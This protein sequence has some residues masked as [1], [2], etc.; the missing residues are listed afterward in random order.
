MN[1]NTISQVVTDG[2]CTGCGTCIALCP[3]ETIKL[4]INENKGIY[5][6]AL[7]ELLYWAFYRLGYSV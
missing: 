1:N 3:E 4:T 7:F 2:L 6:P 5:V